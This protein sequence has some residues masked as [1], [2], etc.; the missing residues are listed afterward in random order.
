MKRRERKRVQRDDVCRQA[1]S[2]PDYR[3]SRSQQW[4]VSGFD[5]GGKGFTAATPHAAR[6]GHETAPDVV[7]GGGTFFS[8]GQSA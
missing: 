8:F 4:L 6:R 5:A 7:G 1:L 2:L 3:E